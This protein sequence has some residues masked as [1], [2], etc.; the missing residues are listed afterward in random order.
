MSDGQFWWAYWTAETATGKLL[1]GIKG[2]THTERELIEEMSNI[3]KTRNQYETVCLG[4][5]NEAA[6]K[7]AINDIIGRKI[8]NIDAV[9]AARYRRP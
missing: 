3:G 5:R 6:A 8:R 4:T 7:H 1:K 9:L 2:W